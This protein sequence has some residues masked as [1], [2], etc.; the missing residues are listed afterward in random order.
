VPV[1][2]GLDLN[3]PV[4]NPALLQAIN[5]VVADPSDSTKDRLLLELN[6][7]IYIAAMLTDDLKRKALE[8]G[9]VE[10]QAG[11]RFEVLC[12]AKGGKKFILLFTDWH[13][14]KAYSDLQVSGWVLPAKDAWSFALEGSTYDG[15]VINPAHNA[16]PLERPM[17]QFLSS[18][19]DA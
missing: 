1:P 6:R 7:A 10:I 2:S 9:L 8:P 15:V 11:S 5:A 3:R 17:L 13:A 14:L 4:E 19:D 12:A 18:R 16:L